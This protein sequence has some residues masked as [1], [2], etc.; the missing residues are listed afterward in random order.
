MYPYFVHLKLIIQCVLETRK[1]DF[2]SGCST[3][4]LHDLYN[5]LTC[6]NIFFYN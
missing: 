4:L 1:V 2:T 6:V 3:K 5:L